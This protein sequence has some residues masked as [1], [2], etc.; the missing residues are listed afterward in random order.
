MPRTGFAVDD[1]AE[2]LAALA[3]LL[4]SLDPFGTGTPWYYDRDGNP[5]TMAQAGVLGE[6]DNYR[7]VASD[8][9]LDATIWVS[10]VWLGQRHPPFNE[11]PPYIFETMVFVQ[12]DEEAIQARKKYWER[13]GGDSYDFPWAD[14]QCRR[15]TNEE[16]ARDGHRE[17]VDSLRIR[18]E[19]FNADREHR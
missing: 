18:E 12:E 14:T 17:I 6:D 10:T 1:E 7:S 16:D 13:S 11:D 5:I 19:E 2:R 3:R 15:Y 4:N 9:L 8:Y